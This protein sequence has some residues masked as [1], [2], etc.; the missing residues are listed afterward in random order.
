MF[1]RRQLSSVCYF[2]VASMLSWA[3]EVGL[4]DEEN[5]RQRGLT[6]RCQALCSIKDYVSACGPKDNVSFSGDGVVGNKNPRRKN[7]QKEPEEG[8]KGYRMTQNQAPYKKDIL[9]KTYAGKSLVFA[10]L[11]DTELLPSFVSTAILVSLAGRR[12]CMLK[13]FCTQSKSAGQPKEDKPTRSNARDSFS[14]SG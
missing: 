1:F 4:A 11:R 13:P 12:S 5:R 10:S 2:H 3:S 8:R 6:E 7:L 9:A 14:Q